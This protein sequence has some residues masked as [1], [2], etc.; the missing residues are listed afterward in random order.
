MLLQN[1]FLFCDREINDIIK[2]EKHSLCKKYVECFGTTIL[3]YAAGDG[4]FPRREPEKL[5]ANL[6]H[7]IAI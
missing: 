5:Y 6:M 4:G 3:N 7:N 2:E 1:Y